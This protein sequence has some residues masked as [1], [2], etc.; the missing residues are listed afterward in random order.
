MKLGI[1]AQQQPGKFPQQGTQRCGDVPFA[2]SDI[3]PAQDIWLIP[4]ALFD[5]VE[6][7]T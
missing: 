5:Q 4:K 3:Y 2:F 7:L 1:G 6:F